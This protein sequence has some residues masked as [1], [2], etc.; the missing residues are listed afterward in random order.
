M[1]KTNSPSVAHVGYRN[2]TFLNIVFTNAQIVHV[3]FHYKE[4][5]DGPFLK[6][7]TCNPVIP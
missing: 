4:N 1:G 7:P 5:I 3:F 2:N 6:N